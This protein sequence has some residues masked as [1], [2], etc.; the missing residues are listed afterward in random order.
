MR[1]IESTDLKQWADTFRSKFVLQEYIQKLIL[2]TAKLN[3]ITCI[4]FPSKDD[5][6]TRGLDGELESTDGTIY[7]PKGHTIWEIS[8]AKGIKEKADSDFE[9]RTKNP[10]GYNPTECFF[11]FVT[12][13]EYN[14]R[15]EWENEKNGLN[16]WID[17]RF[18]DAL[19]LA[20]WFDE[21]GVVSCEFAQEIGKYPKNV[22]ALIHFWK[23][24]CC[25]SLIKLNHKI[26]LANRENEKS[27][28]LDWLQGFI[29]DTEK[30]GR[31]IIKANSLEEAIAFVSAVIETTDEKEKIYY[32]SKA[33]IVN[34]NDSFESI[35][36]KKSQHIIINNSSNII[37]I[38]Y[39]ILKG[40]KVIIPIINNYLDPDITLEN[41]TYNSFLNELIALKITEDRCIELFKETGGDLYKLKCKLI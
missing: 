9:K 36:N 32:N 4:D 40:H 5:V 23:Q 27:Y 33:I 38:N 16:A 30:K 18:Y 19:K 6:N 10:N 2:S 14:A 13:R 20:D 34:D 37:P 21:S 1:W 3:S 41:I 17:V 22:K 28:V 15:N 25:T 24:W 8:E 39:A 11:I 29:S 26:L 12:A 7:I 35:I 31:L